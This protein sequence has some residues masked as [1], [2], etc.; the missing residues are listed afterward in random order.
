MSTELETMTTAVV[1][2]PKG[3]WIHDETATKI[4]IESEGAGHFVQIL[5]EG[6]IKPGMVHID[7]EEWEAIKAAVDRMILDCLA[8]EL[9]DETGKA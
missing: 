5:Q 8:L 9:A 6:I 4:S 7:P 1:V 3:A 2:K